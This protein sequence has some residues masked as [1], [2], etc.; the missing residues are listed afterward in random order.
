MLELNNA[1][2]SETYMTSYNVD[3]F[4]LRFD[5]LPLCFYLL[6]FLLVFRVLSVSIGIMRLRDS[7]L[8]IAGTGYPGIASIQL[9][10]LDTL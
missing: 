8:G 4:G 9:V 2:C 10:L 7:T 1:W 6:L 3:I 5:A